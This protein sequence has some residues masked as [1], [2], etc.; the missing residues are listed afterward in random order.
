MLVS[1]NRPDGGDVS[2]F[3]RFLMEN[4]ACSPHEKIR[5]IVSKLCG[6]EVE[7]EVSIKKYVEWI[8]RTAL[9]HCEDKYPLR[10]FKKKAEHYSTLMKDVVAMSNAIDMLKK[11]ITS[12]EGRRKLHAALVRL[13]DNPLKEEEQEVIDRGQRLL[14]SIDK[15]VAHKKQKEALQTFEEC[16]RAREESAIT[17]Q[18]AIRGALTRA[19]KMQK[20]AAERQQQQEKEAAAKQS[21]P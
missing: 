18:A 19:L 14:T 13:K 16:E 3:I 10:E 2:E 17:V 21:S 4:V 5:T 11:K 20:K 8:Q 9:A 6:V 7:D 12:A 1:P 15:A